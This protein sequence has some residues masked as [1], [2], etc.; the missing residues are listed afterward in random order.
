LL[1]GASG[2][3][4]GLP[5]LAGLVDAAGARLFASARL[6]GAG[7]DGRVAIAGLASASVTIVL[8]RLVEVV[9][10][11]HVVAFGLRNGAGAS[12][13]GHLSIIVTSASGASVLLSEGLSDLVSVAVV[14]ARAGFVGAADLSVALARAS[15]AVLGDGLADGESHSA[16][17]AVA[18][19]RVVRA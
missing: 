7:G 2:A 19:H 13:A 4:V 8:P 12:I 10:S 6:L 17:L 16:I 1:T 5:R 14:D 9:H 11:S 18:W 15:V 3:F